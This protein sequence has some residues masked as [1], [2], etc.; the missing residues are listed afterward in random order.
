V[1]LVAALRIFARYQGKLPPVTSSK[2][3]VVAE[4]TMLDSYYV[5]FGT[6]CGALASRD[7]EIREGFSLLRPDGL[8]LG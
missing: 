5:L 1:Q 7:N 2:F 6:L 4:H 8:L 3:W